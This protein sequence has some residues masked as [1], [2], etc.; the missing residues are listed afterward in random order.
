MNPVKILRPL[1]LSNFKCREEGFPRTSRLLH[2]TV[3]DPRGRT[4][5]QE[6]KVTV[7]KGLGQS[8]AHPVS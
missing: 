1:M 2:C 4:V 6:V 8:R 3:P 5:R 7:E